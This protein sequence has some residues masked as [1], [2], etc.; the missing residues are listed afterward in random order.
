VNSETELNTCIFKAVKKSLQRN[1]K[2]SLG[3]EVFLL[4]DEK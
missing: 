1:K 4:P 3:Q 2:T